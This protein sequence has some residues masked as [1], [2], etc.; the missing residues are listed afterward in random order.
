[1]LWRHS[2][3]LCFIYICLSK[4]FRLKLQTFVSAKDKVTQCY[5]KLCVVMLKFNNFNLL[6]IC[7]TPCVQQQ[8]KSLQQIHKH[9]S[10]GVWASAYI[11]CRRLRY[12]SVDDRCKV[13]KP[14]P[15]LS[16]MTTRSICHGRTVQS[17]V[18]LLELLVPALEIFLEE[19]RS[20]LAKNNGWSTGLCQ[21]WAFKASHL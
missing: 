21:G 14:Q 3:R 8:I 7:C 17:L 11:D 19:A 1:M 12:S 2:R 6:W 18:E 10:D 5:S 13:N 15:L 9:L 16:F 4:S 20:E